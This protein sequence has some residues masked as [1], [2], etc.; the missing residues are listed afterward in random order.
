MARKRRLN[1]ATL[2]CGA[3]LALGS[4]VQFA[5]A[6]E[7][8][9]GFY[10]LGSRGPMAG[11]LPPPGVYLQ[12]DV[13]HM[14]ASADA[15]RRFPFNGQI[16]AGIKADVWLEMPTLLWSTPLQILGGNLAFSVTQPI[17]GPST[18]FGAKLTGPLGNTVGVNLHDSI[19]T[20]GDPVLSAMLGWH[21]G[22]FHWQVGVAVNTPIGDYREGA[23]ANV[24][25]NRWG[26]DVFAAATWLDPKIGL[27]LSLAAGV[28]FNS[29]NDVTQYRTGNEFH[30][31]WAAEQHLSKQF[32][33]GLVGYYYRQFTGDSG[34][35]AVLGPLKGETLALGATMAFNFAVGNAPWSLRLKAYKELEVQNRLEG[36]SGFL[37]LS[38]PLHVAQAAAATK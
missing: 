17:G 30:L 6:A 24:A 13:Y 38:I 19:F 9:A 33:I 29:T 37:T 4:S 32:S 35:G 1:P 5:S 7:N 22:N 26:A 16:V 27:D 18:H 15:S 2:M 12:N 20:Y 25:F 11:F 3:L 31:E 28:T 36:A 34:A 8:G 23:L 21:Q 14:Q 10:L